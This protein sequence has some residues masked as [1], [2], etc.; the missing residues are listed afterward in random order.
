M[1]MTTA[2]WADSLVGYLEIPAAEIVRTKG[3]GGTRRLI[4]DPSHG[5]TLTGG[6]FNQESAFLATSSASGSLPTSRPMNARFLIV[7]G[8]RAAAPSDILTATE[9]AAIW[10]Q[11][12]ATPANF[13]ETEYLLV[14]RLSLVSLFHPV[15]FTVVA[16]A[17]T[18]APSNYDPIYFAWRRLPKI[19]SEMQSI[20]LGLVDP[21]LEEMGAVRAGALSWECPTNTA[22]NRT[23]CRNYYGPAG[24][25]VSG[26]STANCRSVPAL[27]VF[28]CICTSTIACWRL[29]PSSSSAATSSAGT[30]SS[31]SIVLG[32]PGWLLGGMDL[33]NAKNLPAG[34]SF[35]V[36]L[37]EG[38]RV[39]LTHN[40]SI[41]GAYV[42]NGPRSFVYDGDSWSE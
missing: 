9:F 26:G 5:L 2:G 39:N 17:V 29:V 41:V 25:N 10:N 21:F 34:P 23:V 20:S 36:F 13:Q 7:S 37:L 24:Q 42:V 22:A 8:L 28:E 4:V 32:S 31:S 14:H 35:T 27:G 33:V 1:I 11:T 15:T 38:T 18:W 3:Q 30:P 40:G 6:M 19:G 16:S 12:S